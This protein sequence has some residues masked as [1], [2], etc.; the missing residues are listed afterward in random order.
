MSSKLPEKKDSGKK[1]TGKKSTE[2]TKDPVIQI[3]VTRDFAASIKTLADL[4]ERSVAVYCRRV[5]QDHLESVLGINIREQKLQ[6]LKETLASQHDVNINESDRK[7][8]IE[9]KLDG[10]VNT[11]KDKDSYKTD[12]T[13][14]QKQVHKVEYETTTDNKPKR[15]KPKVGRLTEEN[16]Q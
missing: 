3:P 11:L 14:E 13:D 8:I 16:V 7:T 15:K 1:G 12:E 4:D 10:S 9:D 6:K 2:S 5:L